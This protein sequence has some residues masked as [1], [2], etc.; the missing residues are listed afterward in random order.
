MGADSMEEKAAEA[1]RHTWNES[2]VTTCFLAHMLQIYQ[3]KV[4]PNSSQNKL[5]IPDHPL[6]NTLYYPNTW[7][8]GETQA[9]G[10]CNLFALQGRYICLFC[11]QV[12]Y[13]TKP[14]DWQQLCILNHAN[15]STNPSNQHNITVT[16][17]H[18]TCYHQTY[19]AHPSYLQLYLHTF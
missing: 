5:W 6:D 4:L 13:Q 11:L 9:T 12:R 8:K 16:S 7:H 17:T 15:I 3:Y 2:A 14:H 1:A 18:I 19:A 10:S